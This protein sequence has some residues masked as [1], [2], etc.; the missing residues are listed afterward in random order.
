VIRT[1]ISAPF[2]NRE[3]KIYNYCIFNLNSRLINQCKSLNSKFVA[4]T[5]I[6]LGICWMDLKYFIVP[7]WLKRIFVILVSNLPSHYLRCD[8]T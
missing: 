8:I 4:L 2:W 1:R 7:V 3:K 5:L 6:S